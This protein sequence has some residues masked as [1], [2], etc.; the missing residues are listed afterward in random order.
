[1]K[2][3]AEVMVNGKKI[4]TLW[5]PPYRIDVTDAIQPGT[6]QLEINVTNQWTN[7]ILGD[8][9]AGTT[10]TRVLP[11]SGGRGPS[12]GGIGG[13]GGRG[14]RGGAGGGGV[15]VPESGLIGPVQV[16]SVQ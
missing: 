13:G 7:R 14:G 5:K 10:G 3:L 6:N 4:G 11:L 9:A 16:L 2:D 15:S 12:A 1:V 8:A